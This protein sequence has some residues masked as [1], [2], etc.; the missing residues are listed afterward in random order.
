ML[1]MEAGAKMPIVDCVYAILWEGVDPG[2]A[3]TNLEKML[4]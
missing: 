3:F 2:E 1:N 4:H